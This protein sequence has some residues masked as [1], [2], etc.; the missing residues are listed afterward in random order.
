[1]RNVTRLI[2]Y[3]VFLGALYSCGGGGTNGAPTQ[4]SANTP[5]TAE[6]GN[7]T[8]GTAQFSQ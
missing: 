7:T 3:V 5:Q 4:S 2:A 1:V 8:F 6:F